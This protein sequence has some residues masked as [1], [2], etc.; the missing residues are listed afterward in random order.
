MVLEGCEYDTTDTNRK[1][2]SNVAKEHGITIR[3]MDLRSEKGQKKLSIS[4]HHL[5]G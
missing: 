2:L 3:A 1:E 4:I 5:G